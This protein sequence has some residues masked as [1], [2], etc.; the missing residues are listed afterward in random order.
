MSKP[1]CKS[2]AHYKCPCCRS[3]DSSSKRFARRARRHFYKN[4]L[5]QLFALAIILFAS[6]LAYSQECPADK[7]CLTP[8]AAR[9]ALEA[10]DKAKALTAELVEKDKA[11]EMLRAEL[12]NIRLEF[13]KA[14][15]ENSALKQNAVSDRAIITAMI[16][17][18]RTKKIALINLF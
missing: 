8:E 10:G 3:L 17:M 13:A 11:F 14:S 12:Q 16:P 18:L 9:A 6:S 7:V 4:M 1:V 5:K 2:E 15:G